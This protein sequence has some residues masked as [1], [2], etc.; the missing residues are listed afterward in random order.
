MDLPT[1][2]RNAIR[3]EE[4]VRFD[5]EA[6]LMEYL[7][8][9][10][11]IDLL[12]FA[13]MLGVEPEIIKKVVVSSAAMGKDNDQNWEDLVCG[14]VENFSQRNRKKKREILKLAKQIKEANLENREPPST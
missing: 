6:K 11:F 12:G 5:L 3:E 4:E 10:E 14:I 9:F 13:K 8:C 2:V 7:T 1:N